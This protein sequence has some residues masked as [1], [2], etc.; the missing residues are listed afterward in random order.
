MVRRIE[1]INRNKHT[2]KTRNILLI[3]AVGNNKTESIYFSSLNQIQTSYRI[4]IAK[5]NKTDPKGI[6]EDMIKTIKNEQI[7]LKHGDIAIC[8][9]DAVF[10]KYKSAQIDDAKLLASKHGIEIIISNPC[11]E[12]WFIE[13]FGYTTKNFNSNAEVIDELKEK[14]PNYTKSINLHPLIIDKTDIAINN[15]KKL[16]NFHDSIGNIGMCRNPSSEVYKIV[17]TINNKQ[18]AF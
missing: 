17:E 15:C 6:V 11:F 8:V 2:R 9:F 13:H 5:G 12:V 10:G 4:Q 7:D 1:K 3:A 16:E 14:I 18:K